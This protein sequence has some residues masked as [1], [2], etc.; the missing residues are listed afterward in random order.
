MATE[1]I[2]LDIKCYRCGAALRGLAVNA[3]CPK[4][5]ERVRHALEFY[6]TPH[7]PAWIKVGDRV[8]CPHHPEWGVGVV[9]RAHSW[10]TPTAGQRLDILFDSGNNRIL[11]TS[12]TRTE[13]VRG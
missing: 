4:C 12:M 9:R 10:G 6:R 11:T 3:R 7:A 8:R 13:V 5:G 1:R 2:E